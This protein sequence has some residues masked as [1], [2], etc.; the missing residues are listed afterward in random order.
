M[1]NT[2]Q[3]ACLSMMAGC[4][5][6]EPNRE[7]DNPL[8]PDRETPAEVFD[9]KGAQETEIKSTDSGEAACLL[10]EC[11]LP[12]NAAFNFSQRYNLTPS[13][14]SQIQDLKIFH[15]D[16]D[17]Q[18]FLQATC[19]DRQQVYTYGVDEGSMNIGALTNLTQ[20]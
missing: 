2:L 15:N 1:R 14:C 8:D 19:E 5:A 6:E 13:G 12:E 11:S 18:V 20:V 17:F 7:Y 4:G 16:A 9:E 3:V 10:G